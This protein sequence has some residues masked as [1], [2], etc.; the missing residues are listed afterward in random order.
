MA[1][2]RSGNS[3]R[4]PLSGIKS[5]ER[6]KVRRHI[7]HRDGYTCWVCEK[8]VDIKLKDGDPF[9]PTLDHVI[10]RKDGGT[11]DQSNLKL[12]HA[13]CNNDRHNAPVAD[14]LILVTNEV[15]IDGEW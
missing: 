9:A 12:A 1:R 10:A 2:R 14:K 15:A 8:A 6:K 11:D 13:R 7:Y 5:R 3:Y 4:G